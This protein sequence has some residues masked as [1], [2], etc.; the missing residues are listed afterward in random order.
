MS[1]VKRFLAA[2]LTVVLLVTML[3]MTQTDVYAAKKMKLNKKKITLTVGKK[4]TLKVKNKPK[5][6][7]VK[8]KSKNKKI[9]KVSKKGVVRAKKAG[10][11]TIIAKVGKKKL[12]CRIIVKSKKK[13]AGY[14]PENTSV[15]ETVK[16]DS[17]TNTNY[18]SN[19]AGG[20]VEYNHTPKKGE[21]VVFNLNITVSPVTGVAAV[22][23]GGKTYS[24]EHISGNDYRISIPAP[25]TAGKQDIVI[26]G[27]VLDNG[28][29]IQTEY[30]ATVDVLKDAPVVSDIAIDTEKETPELSYEIADKD[31]AFQDGIITITDE[32]GNVAYESKKIESGTNTVSLEDLKPDKKYTAKVAVNYDLDSDV[33]GAP[34]DHRG[35]LEKSK[36]FKLDAKYGFEGGNWNITQKVTKSQKL[37]VTFENTYASYYDVE[38][39][40]VSGKQYKAVKEEN[41]YRTEIEKGKK[42]EKNTVIVQKVVLANGKEYEV[43]Q[44]LEYFYLKDAPTLGNDFTVQRNESKL[45]VMLDIHDEEKTIQQVKVYLT[46]QE[47]YVVTEKDMESGSDFVEFEINQSGNYKIEVEYTYDLGDEVLLK[48]TKQYEQVINEPASVDIVHWNVTDHAGE[49]IS[50]VEKGQP[51]KASFSVDTNVNEKIV[52]VIANS[53]RLPVEAKERGLYTVLFNAP[54]KA[55]RKSIEITGVE[56]EKSGE[57]EASYTFELEVLKAAPL[58]TVENAAAGEDCKKMTADFSL[59]DEDEVTTALYARL[60]SPQGKM[61]EEKAIEKDAQSVF[62]EAADNAVFTAGEYRIE[63]GADYERG[64]GKTHNQ[65]ETIGTGTAR[66]LTKADITN[67]VVKNYYVKRGEAVEIE[68]T[69]SSNNEAAL[70][71]ITINNVYYPAT[72]NENHTYTVSVTAQSDASCG[73]NT[74]TPHSVMYGE[75][76][77]IL[78]SSQSAEYYILKAEPAIENYAFNDKL[79]EQTI[80]FDFVN[81]EKALV[82]DARIVIRQG[83]TEKIS[84]EITSGNNTV[85]LGS[86]ENGTYTVEFTGTYE[87]DDNEDGQNVYQIADLF[88][89]KQ[90]QVVSDYHASISVNDVKVNKNEKQAV[91]TF[92]GT[93]AVGLDIKSIIADD[94]TYEVSRQAEADT[95]KAGISYENESYRKITVTDVILDGDIRVHL[96]EAQN[97]EIFKAAPSVSAVGT[98]VDENKVTVKLQVHDEAE[99]MENAKAVLKDAQGNQIGTPQ[100]VSRDTTEVTFANVNKAG[101][102][103]VEILA[104]Y[105]RVDGELHEQEKINAEDIEVVVNIQAEISKILLPKTYADKKETVTVTYMIYDNTDEL[106]TGLV[107]SDG[108]AENNYLAICDGDDCSIHLI[109]PELDGKKTYTVTKVLYGTKQVVPSGENLT[110]S[111]DVLKT[112]PVIKDYKVNANQDIPTISFYVE[113]PDHVT[114]KAKALVK[115]ETGDTVLTAEENIADGENVIKLSGLDN[116]RIYHFALEGTYILDNGSD[117][118]YE[119]NIGQIFPEKRFQFDTHTEITDCTISNPY[120]EKG[121]KVEMVYTVEDN[122]EIPLSYIVI[123][124]KRHEVLKLQDGTYQ[125]TYTA[126]E[127]CG[128]EMLNTSA[129]GYDNNE[130]EVERTDRIEVLKQ[131]PE[132]SAGYSVVNHYREKSIEFTFDVEDPDQ[133]VKNNK[134][135]ALLC[136]AQNNEEIKRVEVAAKSGQSVTFTEVSVGVSYNIAVIA[137]YDLDTDA[138]NETTKKNE[139]LAENSKLFETDAELLKN[140]LEVSDFAVNT[141]G[142]KPTVSFTMSDDDGSF[143]SGNLIITNKKTKA[144]SKVALEGGQTTYELEL[145][146]FVKHKIELQITYDLDDEPDNHKH[147]KEEIFGMAD[148]VE[149]IGDYHLTFSDLTVKSVNKEESKAVLQFKSD[150]VSDYGV[151]QVQV[152][153]NKYDAQPVEG[154]EN[155]YTFEYEISPEQF[156]TRTTITV[157]AVILANGGIV[158]PESTSSVTIFKQAPKATEITLKNINENQIDVEFEVTDEEKTLTRLY[159]VLQDE[160]GVKVTEKEFE[161]DVRKVSFENVTAKKYQV[162]IQGDYDLADGERHVQQSL[163]TSELITIS[164]AVRIKTTDISKKY[165]KKGETI[166]ITYEIFSNTMLDVSKVVI[167]DIEYSVTKEKGENYKISYQAPDNAGYDEIKVT[168]VIF[169]NN[170]FADISDNPHIDEIDVLKTEPAIVGFSSSDDLAKEMVM[171]KFEVYDPDNAMTSG[172]A[173]VGNQEQTVIQN[174]NSILFQ[175]TPD[176]EHTITIN[177]EYDLDSNRLTGEDE[178]NHKATLVKTEKFTLLSDYELRITDLKTYKK[179]SGEETK[180]FAKNEPIQLRF[181]CTNKTELTPSEVRVNDLEDVSTEGEWF[182]VN[183]VYKDD[184]SVD[185]YYVEIDGKNEPGAE[186]IEL[187]DVK[188]SSGKVVNKTAFKGTAPSADIDILKDKPEI[189]GITVTNNESSVTVSFDVTDPDSALLDSYVKIVEDSLNRNIFKT[190]IR[191]GRNEYTIDLKPAVK[192]TLTIERNYNL[193]SLTDDELNTK[194]EVIETRPIEITKKEEPNFIARNLSVPKR[195]PNGQ[196]VELTFENRVLSYTDVSAITID[197]QEHTVTKDDSNVYH[198]ELDPGKEG[199]HTIHVGNVKM[200]EK[201]FKIN[202]N[203]T[204]THEFI[205]PTAETLTDEIKED[206][207]NNLATID[208]KITDP[209]HSIKSLTAYMRNSAGVVAA[210]KEIEIG[211]DSLSMPLIKSYRYLIDLKAEYDVGDGKTYETVNLFTKE[212]SSEARVSIVS[213]S[214]NK[215]FADKGENV[216]I[217]YKINT[218]F[219]QDLRKVFIGETG[220]SATKL[221]EADTYE[222]TVPAPKAAGVFK[223][224][225]TQMQV[226]NNNYEVKDPNPVA[227]KVFRDKPTLTHFIIDEQNNQLSF[228]LNDDDGALTENAVFTITD[229]SG[230]STTQMLTHGGGDYTFE[231][232]KIGLINLNQQYHAKVNV[233]YD[234]NPERGNQSRQN[235]M[236]VSAEETESEAETETPQVTKATEDIYERDIQLT[237]LIDYNFHFEDVGGYY[238]FSMNTAKNDLDVLFKCTNDSVYKPAKVI[239]DGKEY[240]VKARKLENQYQVL[241]YRPASYDQE[242]LHYEKV[243]LENGMAFDTPASVPIMVLREDQKFDIT[244]VEEDIEEQKIRFRFNLDDKDGKV[245]SDLRF[246]L[247]NSQGQLIES[248]N[249]PVTEKMVEFKIPNPPTAKY[250]L[251]VYGDLFIYSGWNDKDQVLFSGE[252]DS[253][254]NTSILGSTFSTRYPK[255]GETIAIDYI[256]SSTKVVLVDPDDHENLA[257]AVNITTMVINGREYDVQHVEGEKYRVYYT[258]AEDDGLENIAVS[259]INFSNETSETFHRTDTIEVIKEEPSITNYQTVNHLEENKVTFKF[260]FSDPDNALDSNPV[261]ALVDGE[262]KEIHEG[263]NELEFPAKLD[264]LSKFEVK[265]TYD[266]DTDQLNDDDGDENSYTDYTIFEKPFILTGFYNVDFTDVE[267]YKANG[268]KT[269]YFEKGENIKVSFDFSAVEGLSPEKITVDGAEYALEKDP[270]TGKYSVNIKGYDTAGPVDASIDSITLDSGNTVVLNNKKFSFE[271]LKDVVRV[272]SMKYMFDGNNQDKLHLDIAV[273]DADYSSKKLELSVKDEYG[274]VIKTSK[275]LLEAGSNDVT[276]D[277]TSAEKYF[278]TVYSDYDRDSNKDDGINS[279][280]NEKVYKEVATI[281]NR[282]IEMKDVVDIQLYRYG[283]TGSVEKVDSLSVENLDVLEN[284]IV[285]VT[286]RDMPQFFS[287][288]TSYREEEGKL[289]L[290]LEYSDAMVYTGTELKPLEVTLD[291]LED[292]SFGY[293]GSFKSLLEKMREHP[294]DTFVLDKDYDL[295]DYPTNTDDSE[296]VIDFD[297]RG[298][299]DGKGRTISNL[300]KPLFK[301][302]KN[303]TV[304]NLVFK[305]ITYSKPENKSVVTK[306]GSG[307]TISNVHIDGVGFNGGEGS[308]NGN[309]AFAFELKDRSVVQNCSAVNISFVGYY[310]SQVNAGAVSYLYNSTIKNCY[311]QGKIVHG[312]HFNGGLVGIADQ[313]AEISNNIVNMSVSPS[314]DL[315]YGG[316]AGVVSASNGATLKNNLSLVSNGTSLATIY[317]PNSTI[318]EQSENNY[319]L[320][321]SNST[322]NTGKGVGEIAKDEINQ[323][324]FEKLHFDKAIWNLENTSFEQLPTLKGLS[325]SFDD[326]GYQP[327]N[328]EVY[329]PDFN[330]IYHLTNYNPNKEVIYHNMYKLMPFYDAKEILTD[331]NKIDE[332]NYLNQHLIDYVLPYDKNGALVS[333]L[334]TKNYRSLAKISVVFENGE[335]KEYEVDFDD[336]YGNIASYMIPELNVGYNFSKFILN[337]DAEII[338]E[339]VETASKYTYEKDLDPLTSAEDGRLYKEHFE[340]VTKN[341]MKDFVEKMLVN[342]GYVPTFENDVLDNLIRQNIIDNG[343]LKQML[344]AYN[345]FTYWY[346]FSMD[347]VNV[348]ESMM[349]YGS[350]MFDDRMTLLALSDELVQGTNAATNGTGSFYSST[351]AKYTGLSNLGEFLDYYVTALTTYTDGD[352]WFRDHWHGGIY[353]SV[354]INNDKAYYKLWE[355]LK[356]SGAAQN[357]FLPLF[358]VPENSMY[359]ITCPTQIFYGS[360]RIY[361]KNPD[362]PEQMKTFREGKLETFMQ[363]V[364]NFYQFA[365]DYVGEEYLNPF[366]DQQ[367]DMRTTYNDVGTVYNNP[368]TTKEPYHKYFAEAVNKWPASNGTGAYATGSEVFWN[369]I[370]LINGFNVATHETL[371]N[372]DSKIFL[373][374]FGRRGGPEDYTAGNLQQY[375]N[376]GWISPNVMVDFPDTQQI[377]QNFTYERIDTNDELK[378]F[379]AKLID[380]ND[381]LDY[382]EAQAFFTLT[383]EEKAKTAVRVYYPNLANKSEEEQKKGDSTVAYEPLTEQKVKSMK[384]ETMADLWDQQIMLKPNVKDTVI[385][386]P[387]GSTDS[388]YNIRWYQPHGDDGRGDAQSFK[389]LAWEMAGIGGYYDGYMAYFS[390][391]Y[392]GYKKNQPDLKTT[393]LIALRYITKKEDITFRE[394]KLDR[395]K[396]MEKHYNDEGI[397][398]DVK[399]VY[400]AYI[401]ALKNDAKRGDRKL[402][403]STAVKKKYYLQAKKETGD[404]RKSI[405]DK[406]EG[407]PETETGQ[408]ADEN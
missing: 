184:G 102:Y 136:N 2:L 14:R 210:T 404:L 214:I 332:N 363:Q 185:Y 53:V 198:L 242:E 398:I 240:P 154:E 244:G 7:K 352:D 101:K 29:Q 393:D 106:I 197:G 407:T 10:K 4:K 109:M 58:A 204:Y 96:K 139:N 312:W 391:S 252:Y 79:S 85:A 172:K 280:E 350:E 272:D 287:K 220:Y 52:S 385:Q 354:K 257:K 54:E 15:P 263:D 122:T 189:S 318:S 400:Q 18:T 290:V 320:K 16:P 151:L 327:K 32:N 296:A 338:D 76:T 49:E 157:D 261:Y 208:Y 50:H 127:D 153:E 196:K 351:I 112:A 73:V 146:P 212:K 275:N 180:F 89:Q 337:E 92:T 366:V 134:V 167:K 341:E 216:A 347:G 255:K 120:V 98:S 377:T 132:I 397:Y 372:Q 394:Y 238:I 130:F 221:E 342:T 285:K 384:L 86:L 104:D 233:T 223:Q 313:K 215:E 235:I 125:V 188:L 60:F 17:G 329:I 268:E 303:A 315:S 310:L 328:A 141:I 150:N 269:N 36:E 31:G 402:T 160:N 353:E 340:N 168:K 265:A 57:I 62:F 304:E 381:F 39:V 181:H 307:A 80:T 336:Y 88:G 191:T 213:E 274:T 349:F 81:K 64:D 286:M 43:N 30:K 288:I 276:F 1:R 211:K 207:E 292:T 77:V 380:L 325:A 260:H 117:S 224:E 179:E 348:G 190:T 323:A 306:Y 133:A 246:V 201:E 145:P 343:K 67:A 408:Q 324:F 386:T 356:R 74:V 158:K 293:D 234:L 256:I 382:I 205:I 262:R 35:T 149:F 309:S 100:S 5:G 330:R 105:D 152:G 9:A 370:Q 249:V 383:D 115:D 403:E 108:I 387:G 301:T 200:G 159:A 69:V 291:I 247:K 237:G 227:I 40:F 161:P 251:T 183:T 119:Y 222:I 37:Y 267:T 264:T 169:A 282:Y 326:G 33:F 170:D 390:Q 48:D 243:I 142:K 91:I 82:K 111:I 241:N 371:H 359:V 365:S 123:N 406:K 135:Y 97:F 162:E 110:V 344:Y 271:I 38:S 299:L 230:K 217:T 175:V 219:E 156:G 129:L 376:D 298:T 61:L 273:S 13:A 229:N 279:Y 177:V 319:H 192:Y 78:G 239:V 368:R 202:R 392:I 51:L 245:V 94:Q 322:K 84:Q 42:G 34:Q 71:G 22:I 374:G 305:G 248:V 289:K 8:W 140:K 131:K 203:L 369:V 345:Y 295:S 379:Y 114:I 361:I 138:L 45:K 302:L 95:Y 270:L 26:T 194:H 41:T 171:F 259:Q 118:R 87:L 333:V 231:L 364:K 6:V 163:K 209:H 401:N 113:N 148:D 124:G 355:H 147:S 63:I 24:A 283:D 25:M 405:F 182:P 68:Y 107:I 93:N 311:V 399:E 232:N 300:H 375:Y 335:E 20:S 126:K 206:V 346:D 218:N 278:I 254:V 143:V 19:V 297:F 11:T 357:N 284:C 258:A 46:D 12:K 23:S 116:N 47:G 56:F 339:L 314:Y 253:K 44:E 155:I 294:E 373:K 236:S 226:G 281:N 367:Y 316:N 193:D 195:V 55:G 166:D 75:E 331:G 277:K 70:S 186:T 360:L 128:I 396:K 250:Q 176:I 388:L 266:L 395:Y 187:Y 103:T 90:I 59:T 99:I 199:V 21:N 178:S 358:T 174:S 321:E 225:V 28:K 72:E 65:K 378:D 165:P 144:V 3:P 121:G 317:S 228:K 83:E 334:T 308:K 362:D 66:I 137:D 173:V 164:P 389:W 27:I